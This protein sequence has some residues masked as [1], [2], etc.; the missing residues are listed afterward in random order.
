MVKEDTMSDALELERIL[1]ALPTQ[2]FFGR[3]ENSSMFVST[4]VSYP[5]GVGAVVRI[6]RDRNGFVVSDDGYAGF[7]ADTMN[8]SRA[9]SKVAPGVA[10]RSGVNFERGTFLLANV[11]SES[12]P[13]AIGLIANTSC[14]SI[15]RV[16]AALEQPRIKRSRDIFDRRLRAAYGDKVSF[17][18]EYKGATGRNWQFDA[19][20]EQDGIIVRLFELVSPTTQAVAIANLKFTDTQALPDPPNVIAALSD[21]DKTDPALRSILSSAGG[22]VIAANDDVSK[23]RLNAA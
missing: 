1:S 15:E 16:L 3:V 4:G 9:F 18:L 23:Y 17:D 10:A 19:G 14:R 2:I 22:T 12:L 6:D 8:A 11:A 13:V 20:V 21:Y 5:N 7:T